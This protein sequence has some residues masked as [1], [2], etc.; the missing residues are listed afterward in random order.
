[1]GGGS[2]LAVDVS[3]VLFLPLAARQLTAAR[4]AGAAGATNARL[5]DVALAYVDLLQVYAELQSNTETYQNA[6]HL[7]ELT[8]SYERSGKGAAADT[9]RTRTEANV[10]EQ[11]RLEPQGRAGVVSARLTQL[12]LLR[13]EVSL[14]PAEPA[15]VPVA[16]VPEQVPL[17]ELLAQ[18]LSNRPELAANRA[19]IVAALERWRAAKVAPLVPN[20]RLAYAAGG[21]GG[22]RN[23]FLGNFDGR[24]DFSAMAVWQLRNFGLGDRALQRERHSQY[25]Q[26]AFRQAAIEATVASQVVA[27]FSVAFARRR[28]LAAAQRAVAAA[29]ESYRLN[30]ERIRR[31]PEQ[32]R[33]IELLQAIQALARARQDYLQVVA[34]YNRAQFRLYTALGNPPLC[35]LNSAAQVAV[36][37]PTAPPTPKAPE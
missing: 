35:A 5:L 27:A 23:D 13:P 4:Q 14:R 25:A 10:R 6:R 24:S 37:E 26:A 32:G 20:L 34:D 2:A 21:F 1:M 7:L 30:E 33:P 16:L 11:E 18:A 3:D 29:R 9:A 22:G 15:V 36:S 12:L 19:L 17:P 31:A 28:E 8:E